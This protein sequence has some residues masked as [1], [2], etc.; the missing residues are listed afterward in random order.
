MSEVFARKRE[1]ETSQFIDIK[2]VILLLPFAGK[3]STILEQVSVS[4]CLG[5]PVSVRPARHL[6]GAHP[7]IAQANNPT[8]NMKKAP[9]AFSFSHSIDNIK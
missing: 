7:A 8:Y 5:T 6:P 9:A 4:V 2:N 1:R 3:H